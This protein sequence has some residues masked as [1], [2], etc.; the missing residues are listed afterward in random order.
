MH[1]TQE[2]DYLALQGLMEAYQAEGYEFVTME[3][4][5]AD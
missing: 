5:I 4:M 3:E 2:A 1:V